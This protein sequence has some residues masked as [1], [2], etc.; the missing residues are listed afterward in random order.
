MLAVSALALLSP[1]SSFLPLAEML[2][3]HRPYL[4]MGV[5]ALTWLL[6]LGWVLTAPFARGT[7]TPRRVA[8]GAV[9][10]TV[11]LAR[12]AGLLLFVTAI[13]GFAATTWTRNRTFSTNRAYLEDVVR[14]APSARA[15]TNLGLTYMEDNDA[16]TA[17]MY[18][19]RAEAL[20]PAWYIVHINLALAHRALGNTAQG[21]S[22]IDRAV[23]VDQFSGTARTWRAT[24][25]LQD[26]RYAEAAQDL[27]AARP[28]STD[29]Y[30]LCRGLVEAYAGLRDAARAIAEARLCIATDRPRFSADVVPM[31]SP[32]FLDA[33]RAR[34][35]VQFFE[36][37]EAEFPEAWWIHANIAT[38]AR[39]A[40]DMVRADR[41]EQRSAE[42][43]ARGS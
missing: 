25:L 38:L 9:P 29:V 39:T 11:A 33:A 24:F 7:V 35:G 43:K 16:R 42:L 34:A 2:N 36:A 32:F 30:A 18:Y 8:A 20:A 15:L 21:W 26:A 40:G 12:F 1:T 41:A 37:L 14:K 27:L 17:L 13:A 19:T 6:P 5:L 22:H 4:P 10:R 3:E 23:T 28:R 31:V